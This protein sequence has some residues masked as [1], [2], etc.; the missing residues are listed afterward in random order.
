M[1][2]NWCFIFYRGASEAEKIAVDS[3]L[4]LVVYSLQGCDPTKIEKKYTVVN[5]TLLLQ[6]FHRLSLPSSSRNPEFEH[7]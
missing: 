5:C 2:K 4:R 7:A 1:Y 6:Y 3:P